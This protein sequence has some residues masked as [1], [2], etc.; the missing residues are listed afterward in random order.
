MVITPL[1]AVTSVKGSSTGIFLLIASCSNSY[2]LFNPSCN[3]FFTLLS[4]TLPSLKQSESPSTKFSCQGRCNH[5]FLTVKFSNIYD[6][7]PIWSKS[8]CVDITKSIVD[9]L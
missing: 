6:K 1:N 8:G 3:L 7:P 5:N 2:A 4:V 9:V